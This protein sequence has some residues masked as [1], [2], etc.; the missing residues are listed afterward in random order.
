[1][2][3]LLTRFVS[4]FVQKIVFLEI[5]IVFCVFHPF[6][7]LSFFL[8]QFSFIFFSHHYFVTIFFLTSKY[9]NIFITSQ[10]LITFFFC[11]TFMFG[12]SFVVFLSSQALWFSF[13]VDPILLVKIEKKIISQPERPPQL[14]SR[15]L[16]LR[17]VNITNA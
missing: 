10:T 9:K 14:L 11:Y 3:A 15:K 17:K 1:M 5:L 6:F 8:S 16:H 4:C 13:S 2:S 12:F 7:F